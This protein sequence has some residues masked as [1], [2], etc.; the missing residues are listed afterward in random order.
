MKISY[1][2]AQFTWARQTSSVPEGTSWTESTSK[3][4]NSGSYPENFAK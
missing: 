2:K 4:E 3:S 1:G